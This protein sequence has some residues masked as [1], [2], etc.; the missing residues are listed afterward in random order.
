MARRVKKR[1]FT[2]TE[3][4]VLVGEVETH[5]NILFGTL[6][7]GVTNKRKNATWEKVTTA[8]NAVGSEER[9][10]SEI[11]KKWFDIKI[12][13]KKCVTAHRHEISATGGQATTQLSPMDTRIASIIGDTALCGIIPD[14][15]TDTL[16]TQ[17]AVPAVTLQETEAVEELGELEEQE[18]P[19]PSK[20]HLVRPGRARVLTEAVLQNQQ[21]TTNSIN[22]IKDQLTNIANTLLQ[23]NDALEVRISDLEARY[24]TTPS[25]VV[26]AGRP[27]VALVSRPPVDPEQP[28]SHGEW[29]TVRGKRS[30]NPLKPTAHHQPILVSNTFS[31]LSDAP[32]EEQTLVIGSSI[33]RNVKLAKPAAIVKCIPGARAGDVESYLKLLAK[34]KRKYHKIVIH[35]GGN[36]SRLRQSEVTKINVESVCRYAKTMSDTVVFSGP[37][38][39]VTSDVMYSRMASFHRWLSRWCPANHTVDFPNSPANTCPDHTVFLHRWYLAYSAPFPNR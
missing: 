24:R 3:I 7:A 33:V 12:R 10:L 14:G 30:G 2:D 39:N 17:P 1:N 21:D 29:V 13:A 20:I 22:E 26:C 5:Q 8:V 4:E 31:P 28:G 9:S 23:I 15:D 6:N 27:A 18:Q 37:L 34:D 25:P 11:K 38:P 32:A 19:G 16:P 35:V 36:D